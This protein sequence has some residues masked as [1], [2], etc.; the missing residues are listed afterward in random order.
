MVDENGK[1][2]APTI[3]SIASKKSEVAE[4]RIFAGWTKF[5]FL[6]TG[7]LDIVAIKVTFEFVF[8]AVD[9]VDVQLKEVRRRWL[10]LVLTLVSMRARMRMD[11]A[12]YEEEETDEERRESFDENAWTEELPVKSHRCQT[13][14]EGHPGWK[15]ESLKLGGF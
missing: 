8:G 7:D 10:R 9:G 11:V 15:R 14:G 4:G 2:T 5:R 6:E 13:T 3:R 12:G 1:A